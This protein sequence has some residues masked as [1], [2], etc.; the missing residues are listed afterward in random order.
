MVT[1]FILFFE[2]VCFRKHK[3]K[4]QIKYHGFMLH[5]SAKIILLSLHMNSR[6]TI[7]ACEDRC[8]KW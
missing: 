8:L 6:I 2:F 3:K 7:N 4:R 1:T 5:T